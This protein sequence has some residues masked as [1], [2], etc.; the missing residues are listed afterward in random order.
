MW[1]LT[2]HLGLK[3]QS[4]KYV[5]THRYDV[6]QRSA[7]IMIKDR[8]PDWLHDHIDSELLNRLDIVQ[9]DTK[10]HLLHSVIASSNPSDYFRR[11]L[12]E[13]R[14]LVGEHIDLILKEIN[15][16]RTD[17]IICGFGRNKLQSLITDDSQLNDGL[18]WLISWYYKI[19]LIVVT[20]YEVRLIFSNQTLDHE[21]SYMVLLNNSQG[22]VSPVKYK[23]SEDASSTD[24]SGTMCFDSH[25]PLINQLLSVVKNHKVNHLLDAMV[26]SAKGMT[27]KDK[28]LISSHPIEYFQRIDEVARLNKL[29]L[30]DLLKLAAQHRI[31]ARDGKKRK[32]KSKLI[33]D[34]V[35][36]THPLKISK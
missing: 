21:R 29:R 3:Q 14:E 9:V 13:R 23:T 28:L 35:N 6:K 20:D 25:H 2:N 7:E 33:E 31:S 4:W 15:N 11:N 24:A 22:W 16:E 18:Y 26:D 19:N 34:L 32:L 10:N 36:K 8:L 1:Q 12:L 17:P 27:L 5:P 30:E